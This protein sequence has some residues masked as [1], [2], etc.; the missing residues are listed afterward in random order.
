MAIL[1]VLIYESGEQYLTLKAF[2]QHLPGL[3]S[4]ANGVFYANLRITLLPSF[5]YFCLPRLGIELE[6]W[7]LVYTTTTAMPDPSCICDLHHSSWQ[8]HILNPLSKARDQTFNLIAT[9]PSWELQKECTS[10]DVIPLLQK[11]SWKKL[12]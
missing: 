12:I 1:H 10:N 7:P 9:V 11:L 6:L 4:Y 3:F 2:K 5:I 8:F